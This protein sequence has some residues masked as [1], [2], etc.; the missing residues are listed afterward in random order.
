MASLTPADEGVHPFTMAPKY[1]AGPVIPPLLVG[2]DL[3]NRIEHVVQ[4]LAKAMP[5]RSPSRP[6]LLRMWIAEGVAQAERDLV[7]IER[8][9]K[10]TRATVV[11][12]FVARPNPPRRS[13]KR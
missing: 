1:E 11:Q 8:D 6:D 12:Q 10:K 5:G 4:R 9:V 2:D 3:G 13:V 7:G